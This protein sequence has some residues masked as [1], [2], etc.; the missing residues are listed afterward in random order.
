MQKGKNMARKKEKMGTIKRIYILHGWTYSKDEIDPLDKWIPFMEELES[1]NLQPTILRIPGLTKDINEVWNLEKYI[2]WLGKILSKEK[3]KVILIGHSNGGR[4]AFSFT[5]KYPDKIAK[6]IL[7]D[8][9]GIYHNELP[10]RLKRFVFKTLAKVGKKITSSENLKNILYKLAREGDY[11]N[12]N[13]SQRQTMLNLVNTDLSEVLSKIET[14]TLI[15]WGK[16]DK[17]TPLSDGKLMHKLIKDS[18][19][20]II[21]KARHAPQFINL[22]EVV[23]KIYDF[24]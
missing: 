10:I 15:I 14:P 8:S 22:S 11:K 12:A 4:I 13:P 7:I 1:K 5:E 3:G 2:D 21:D 20:H 19:L 9:A 17:V 16:E 18:R 24:I 6:L 23:K